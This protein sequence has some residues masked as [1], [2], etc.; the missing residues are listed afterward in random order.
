MKISKHFVMQEFLPPIQ[1]K[2]IMKLS[3]DEMRLKAFYKLI[4]RR[5]IDLAEYYRQFFGRAIIVNNW[6]SGGTYT[7]RGWRPRNSKIGAVNS[8]HKL[9]KAFDCDVQGWTAEEVRDRIVEQSEGKF[10]KQFY[11]AG[12]RRLEDDVSWVHSDI[13]EVENYKDKIYLFKP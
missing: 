12:L 5:I 9:G 3:T 6:H 13:K 7:L 8:M 1:Y 10:Q 11:D 4:D 2:N